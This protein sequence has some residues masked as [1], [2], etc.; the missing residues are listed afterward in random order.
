MEFN[1]LSNKRKNLFL[2]L[3]GRDATRKVRNVSSV[4]G[5]VFVSNHEVSHGYHSCFFRP[6]C[7]STLFSVPGGMST[8]AFPDIVTVPVFAVVDAEV[9]VVRMELCIQIERRSVEESQHRLAARLARAAAPIASLCAESYDY[10]NHI[11]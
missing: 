6:A 11:N 9:A 7:F 5:R 10:I 3:A 4:G 2:G 8:L 1:G